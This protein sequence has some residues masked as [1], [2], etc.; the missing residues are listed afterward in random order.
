VSLFGTKKVGE[1]VVKVASLVDDQ[2]YK[3][4]T[5][6]DLIRVFGHAPDCKRKNCCENE[7]KKDRA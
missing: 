6:D 4:I 3:T 2:T 5:G 7:R 1:V